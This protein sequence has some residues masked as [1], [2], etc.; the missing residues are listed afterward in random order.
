M[1]NNKQQELDDINQQIAA[2]EKKIVQTST[3]T[4]KEQ[5]QKEYID[6][7]RKLTQQAKRLAEEANERM[8]HSLRSSFP[9]L[10]LELNSDPLKLNFALP[11]TPS[12]E[13]LQSAATKA[14]F[15]KKE[16]LEKAKGLGAKR[17]E[18]LS[19]YYTNE[20]KVVISNEDATL[21][22]QLRAET[23]ELRAEIQVLKS[24]LAASKQKPKET[25]A[26]EIA[27]LAANKS[28]Q[29]I[30]SL[31]NQ[32][33]ELTTE[34]KLMKPVYEVGQAIRTGIVETSKRRR[35]AN[36]KPDH[37]RGEPDVEIVR[38]RNSAAHDGHAE[39]DFALLR[40]GTCVNMRSVIYDMYR[41]NAEDAQ[42]FPVGVGNAQWAAWYS[43]R[44]TMYLCWANT[45]YTPDVDLERS[46]DVID[47]RVKTCL[48]SHLKAA[49]GNWAVAWESF[50]NDPRVKTDIASM[51]GIAGVFI[52][53]ERTR[54]S[55]H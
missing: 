49:S 38:A 2:N 45:D 4:A 40:S 47:N 11:T 21:E 51:G 46:F 5:A 34:I 18:I 36:E 26:G 12:D 6:S 39:A 27:K 28:E 23:V 44:A 15:V 29:Q 37:I 50:N 17:L 43:A 3:S 35:R 7:T 13:I 20:R 52:T 42:N 41:T 48:A 1:V 16:L 32:V 8:K 31:M 30:S 19:T 24:T 9:N 10:S 53:K 55:D 14:H 33:N 25:L 22:K 54:L